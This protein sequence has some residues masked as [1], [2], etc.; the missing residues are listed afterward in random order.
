MIKKAGDVPPTPHVPHPSPVGK[1]SEVNQTNMHKTIDK[2]TQMNPMS[3]LPVGIG[4][5]HLQQ[6]PPPSSTTE[7]TSHLVNNLLG[8]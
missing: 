8:G 7:A 1:S 5:H 4:R 6:A 3:F 2:I